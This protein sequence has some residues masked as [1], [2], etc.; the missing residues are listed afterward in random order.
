VKVKAPTERNFRRARAK[1]AKRKYLTPLFSWKVVRIVLIGVVVSLAAFRAAQLAYASEVFRVSHVAVHGNVRVSTGEVEAMVRELKG[2][3][4]LTTDLRAW[5]GKLLESPWVAEVSLR[6]VLPATVDVYISERS[7]FGLGRNGDTLY[8]ISP[9]GTVLDEFGP[10]YSAFDLP[11]VDGLFV[12]K[13]P[14]RAKRGRGTEPTSKVDAARAALAARV[15]ESIR[16]SDQLEPRLSQ[17]DVSDAHDAVVLL[18]GDPAL[19]HLG[20]D[21][22][23]E[24]LH[25]YLEYAERLRERIPNIDS[26]DLRFEERVYVKPRGRA[27][28]TAM[29]LPTAGRTF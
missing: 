29:P 3:N 21:R 11:I 7:A 26:V 23:R 24:R 28:R 12:K 13:A 10:R 5:R 9:D 1:P 18:D 8:L 19:L 25:S 14:S 17:I 27:D 15:I 2:T 4:I 20:E 22:F 16:G 6:R